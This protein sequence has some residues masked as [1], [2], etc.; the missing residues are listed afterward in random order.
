MQ[1]FTVARDLSRGHAP[2]WPQ[3]RWVYSVFPPSQYAAQVVTLW[4]GRA[5]APDPG[6]HW[7]RLGSILLGVLGTVLIARAAG[8]V[9]RDP[10][11]GL[12]AGTAAAL[13]PQY[14]F[15]TAYCNADAYTIFAGLL[16]IDALATW[17]ALGEGSAGLPY[18]GAAAGVVLS[19]KSTAFY[20]LPL[21]A[22][23]VWSRRPPLRSVLAAVVLAAAV[24]LPWLA[25][26]AARTGGDALGVELY[27]KYMAEVWHPRTLLQVRGG[28]ADFAS[29]MASS[30]I[31][32]FG[33]MSLPLPRFQ[34]WLVGALIAAGSIVSAANRPWSRPARFIAGAAVLNVL[35]E[36]AKCILI[37]F[38]PQGRHVLVPVLLLTAVALIG[39]ARR[40]PRWPYPFLAILAMAAATMEWQLATRGR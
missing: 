3:S 26:N 35:S 11:A 10:R 25:W 28:L 13:Y 12:L 2:V 4:I 27:R 22:L 20:L 30:A 29:L 9:T 5:F 7:A 32:V 31:G 37:D 1:H 15:V 33:N 40:W 17:V 14:A 38:S 24:A 34:L 23:W 18:V 16:L 19:A 6:I 21:G 8:R 36:L 39:P